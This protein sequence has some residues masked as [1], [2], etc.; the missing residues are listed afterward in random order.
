MNPEYRRKKEELYRYG[1][2]ITAV[3]FLIT[4]FAI[5]PSTMSN[6]FINPANRSTGSFNK[7]LA[8]I[9][10]MPFLEDEVVLGVWRRKGFTIDTQPATLSQVINLDPQA[11][12]HMFTDTRLVS[13]ILNDRQI[14]EHHVQ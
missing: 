13:D 8:M 14:G 10:N 7:G 6:I 4:L 5:L 12:G 3:G 2:I 9:A 1:I 11:V